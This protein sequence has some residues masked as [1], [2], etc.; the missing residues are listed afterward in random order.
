M[1]QK[2][3][4]PIIDVLENH[5]LEI[6]RTS[7][8]RNF[9]FCP[10]KEENTPSLCVYL[11][12]NSWFC[13]GCSEGGDSID[14]E[15][16]LSG[17][18]LGQVL[19]NLG[20]VSNGK[21]RELEPEEKR[22]KEI[23]KMTFSLPDEDADLVREWYPLIKIILTDRVRRRKLGEIELP[24]IAR[25]PDTERL[26][27]ILRITSE[28]YK[29]NLHKPENKKI[30]DYLVSR[31]L[32]EKT[33]DEFYLGYASDSWG[34]LM[35]ELGY[36]Y[37][38]GQMVD[39]GVVTEKDGKTYDRFRGRII[40][41]IKTALG[42]IVGFGSRRL[43]DD[44]QNIKYL[45]SAENKLFKKGSLLF[46]LAACTALIPE[47]ELI[48][49]EGYFDS[50]ALLSVGLPAVAC[51]G[52]AFTHEQAFLISKYTKSVILALDNDD[53]GKKAAI[54]ALGILSA[55]KIKVRFVIF[56]D[57]KDP[58]EILEKCGPEQLKE[59]MENTIKI[60]QFYSWAVLGKSYNNKILEFFPALAK[61]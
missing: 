16:R 25:I 4:L 13:F 12:T 36:R 29:S 5:E 44:E 42:N 19:R 40:I 3:K 11:E 31:G 27:E 59:A 30:K 57:H 51:L 10:F 47:K 26:F 49:T 41:P 35:S 18:T 1:S 32:S 9:Y 60:T 21:K 46:G 53:A 52:T 61:I 28:F 8:G 48:I 38:T 17:R 55:A 22:L 50:I 37:H 56:K 23:L 39:A 58:S 20:Y 33:M 34:E 54:K 15:S 7:N 24:T 14:L 43:V 45:N 6:Q 2:D